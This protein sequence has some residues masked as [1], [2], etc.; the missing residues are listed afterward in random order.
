[1]KYYSFKKWMYE[2]TELEDLIGFIFFILLFI[3]KLKG[4]NGFVTGMM[5]TIIGYYFGHK[6]LKRYYRGG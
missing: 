4:L 6:Y 3:L 2:N 1:M 5:V